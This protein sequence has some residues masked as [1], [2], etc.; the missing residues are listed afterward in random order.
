M[1]MSKTNRRMSHEYLDNNIEERTLTGLLNVA[2]TWPV[3][4]NIMLSA[5]TDRR[6]K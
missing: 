3:S 1:P 4:V 5:P 2:A 6:A